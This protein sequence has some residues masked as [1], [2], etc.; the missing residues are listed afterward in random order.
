MKCGA[1]DLV[2]SPP[3]P[4]TTDHAYSAQSS[5]PLLGGVLLEDMAT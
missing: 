1:I 3:R 4:P 2:V 5:I